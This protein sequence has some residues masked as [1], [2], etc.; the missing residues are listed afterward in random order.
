MAVTIKRKTGG[1]GAGSKMAIKVNGEKVAKIA[2]QQAIELNIPGESALIKVEQF[3]I[4]SNEIEVRNGDAV[5]ITTAKITY[6]TVLSL[7]IYI[8]V[9][10]FDQMA[11][12][13]TLARTIFII[14]FITNFIFANG[15]NL[16]TIETIS[17]YSDKD[18]KI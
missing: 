9:S 12:Y 7:L 3:G 14:L 11:A 15:F 2:H 13:S 10:S 1:A 16:K 17:N 8:I 4:K 18:S 5:K 6:F